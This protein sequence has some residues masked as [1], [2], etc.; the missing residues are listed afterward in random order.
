MEDMLNDTR[1][2][3]GGYCCVVEIAKDSIGNFVV[4]KAIKNSESDLQE[5]FFEVISSAREDLTRSP[6]A[7][8]VL[9]RVDKREKQLEYYEKKKLLSN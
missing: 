2:E 7:K 5:K 3:V 1:E 9:A 8:Y 4:N 6:Y